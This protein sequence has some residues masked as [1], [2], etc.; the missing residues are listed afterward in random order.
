LDD[1]S[2]EFSRSSEKINDPE[3]L[4][5]LNQSYNRYILY[6]ENTSSSNYAGTLMVQSNLESTVSQ[7]EILERNC[8]SNNFDSRKTT[9][10]DELAQVIHN[11]RTTAVPLYLSVNSY[12]RYVRI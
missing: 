12:F 9:V 2:E 3:R 1:I 10:L 7:L 11:N 5:L 4:A 8:C 6:R